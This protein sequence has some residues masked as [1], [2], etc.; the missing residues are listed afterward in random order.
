MEGGGDDVVQ[1]RLELRREVWHGELLRH[2]REDVWQQM[3]HPPR[4]VVQNRLEHLARA[5]QLGRG[6]EALEQD[7]RTERCEYTLTRLHAALEQDARAGGRTAIRHGDRATQLCHGG[8]TARGDSS[9]ALRWR[10]GGA[11]VAPR[12]GPGGRWRRPSRR[13][14][15]PPR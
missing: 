4:A 2:E 14:R 10:C 6:G 3:V 15:L 8:D 13:R 7:L 9:V 5:A 1:R 12:C 11:A